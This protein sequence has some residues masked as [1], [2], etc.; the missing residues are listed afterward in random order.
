METRQIHNRI[1]LYELDAPKSGAVAGM[2]MRARQNFPDRRVGCI[3][4]RDTR[5]A[6]REKQCYDF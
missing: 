4:L 5:Y 6:I 1:P 2:V 3:A